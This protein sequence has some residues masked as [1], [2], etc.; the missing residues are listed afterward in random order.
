MDKAEKQVVSA[1]HC[2]IM[3][4]RGFSRAS[5]RARAEASRARRAASF[6]GDETAAMPWVKMEERREGTEERSL[7]VWMIDGST[8]FGSAETEEIDF[9]VRWPAVRTRVDG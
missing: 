7:G 9:L 6:D 8:G 5:T 3:V 2:R 4:S 1:Q